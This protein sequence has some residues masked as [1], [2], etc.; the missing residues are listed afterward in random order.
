MQVMVL[1]WCQQTTHNNG[2]TQHDS[3]RKRFDSLQ[4]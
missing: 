4:A 3:E 1:Y 2:G